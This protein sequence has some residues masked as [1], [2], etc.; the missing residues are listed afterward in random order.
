[1]T[2]TPMEIHNKEFSRSFRGYNDDEVDEFLDK[3]VADYEKMYKENMEIKD[4]LA[5]IDDQIKSYKKM[6]SALKETLITAQK[7]ADEVTNNAHQKSELIISEAEQ[8]AK[9]IIEEANK[10][11][12]EIKKEFERNRKQFKIFKSRFKSL[13]ETQLEMIDDEENLFE[14]DEYDA[15]PVI[16]AQES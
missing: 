6:E 14:Y 15:S 12:I 5:L 11:V 4:K 7:T 9:Q 13:L 10:E 8:K 2:I 1:M 16:E 3:V